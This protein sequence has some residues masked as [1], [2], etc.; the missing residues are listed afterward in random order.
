MC[1]LR[2]A[3][4]GKAYRVYQ[5]PFDSLKE[6]FLKREYSETFWAL[7][8][9][10]FEVETGDSLGVVGDNGAG[11]STLLKLLTGA[12]A[13]S[14]GRVERF[15]RVAAIL[16]LGAGFHPDLSGTD[17]IRV[18]CAVLGL[19]PSETD[20]LLPE[21]VRFSGL[22]EFMDR[23]VRTYS[24]GMYLRL[25]FSVATAVNPD[26]LVIDE[27]LS[28]GDQQ[29]RLKCKR[30][31]MDLRAG[32]CTIVFCSHDLGSV[33]EVC[34]RTL[35]VERGR[36]KMYGQTQLVLDAYEAYSMKRDAETALTGKRQQPTVNYL[37]HAWLGGD[38]RDGE[39]RTGGTLKLHLTVRLDEATFREGVIAAVVIYRSDGLRCYATSTKTDEVVE[40]VYPLG[41]REYGV[42][43]V[44]DELPLMSGDYTFIVA[45][46]DY[47]TSHTFDLIRQGCPFRVRHDGKDAGVARIR[48]RW[49]HP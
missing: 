2:A 34:H 26:V 46:Q 12:L 1:A 31:I 29:F 5:R 49:E 38:F 6:L 23:L 3:A 8:D 19:S 22:G 33:R 27:H 28:V 9:V 47:R 39:I 36:P 37:K 16:T 30:R 32:G 11:K 42:T 15:G 48:H 41:D 13:P 43:F 7:R 21:I 25:G 10:T 20:I 4:L 45:L 44:V 17:N 18:G 40:A 24:S 14:T 35:W